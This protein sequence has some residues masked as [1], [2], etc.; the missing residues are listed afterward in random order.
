MSNERQFVENTLGLRFNFLLVFV[1]IIAGAASRP[2]IYEVIRSLMLTFATVICFL[3][4]LAIERSSNQLDIIIEQLKNT[5]DHPIK[6]V[7]EKV[8]ESG[9]RRWIIGIVIPRICW[10][11]LLV[12][13]ATSWSFSLYY[14]VNPN[15]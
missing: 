3:L 11:I 2:D 7:R 9:S 4:S 8:G 6:I 15:N 14:I 10:M 13:T 1:S 5:P 12:F